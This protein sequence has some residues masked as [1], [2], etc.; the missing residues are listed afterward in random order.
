MNKE[1]FVRGYLSKAAGDFAPSESDLLNETAT[2]TL[3]RNLAMM[4]AKHPKKIGT[5]VGL[6]AGAGVG[7]LVSSIM[8]RNAL[9]GAGYGAGIGGLTGL[10][11]GAAAEQGV[12][13]YL[14]GIH[15]LRGHH[16]G[17]ER[18][19]KKLGYKSPARY[20][21]LFHPDVYPEE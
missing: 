16:A 11:A 19:A 8:G 10:A 9:K 6:G 20:D 14:D 12:Q 13:S 1:A 4:A 7:A 15:E 18:L 3:L 17:Q 2:F 21:R 5:G